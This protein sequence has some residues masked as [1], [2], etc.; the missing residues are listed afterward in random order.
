[1]TIKQT[2]TGNRQMWRQEKK[3]LV[4]EDAVK[5]IFKRGIQ[6]VRDD[7]LELKRYN[8]SHPDLEKPIQ[9]IS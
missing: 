4:N 8:K 3:S 7:D 9:K 1:M 6:K 2:E 5:M